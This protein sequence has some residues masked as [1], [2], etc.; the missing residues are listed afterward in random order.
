MELY[1]LDVQSPFQMP[2][3]FKLLQPYN[4]WNEITSRSPGET[5][6][7]YASCNIH[8]AAIKV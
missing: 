4:E 3:W 8:C 1:E 5:D 6:V 7:L 2:K